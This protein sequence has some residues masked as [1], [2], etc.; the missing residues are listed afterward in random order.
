MEPTNTGRNA[1]DLALAVLKG[2]QSLIVLKAPISTAVPSDPWEESFSSKIRL[3]G[4]TKN[5]YVRLFDI[6]HQYLDASMSQDVEL[7]TIDSIPDDMGKEAVKTD[8]EDKMRTMFLEEEGVRTR[9]KIR[10]LQKYDT[11][12][13]RTV[14][15]LSCPRFNQEKLI[16]VFDG[17][18][19]HVPKIISKDFLNLQKKGRKLQSD[20]EID[21]KIE[22]VERILQGVP[23]SNL[24]PLH[25]SPSYKKYLKDRLFHNADGNDSMSSDS[26]LSSVPDEEACDLPFSM[27]SGE[28]LRAN[29]DDMELEN[30][31][32]SQIAKETA[33]GQEATSTLSLKYKQK[34]PDTSRFSQASTNATAELPRDS[35][36]ES[37][38]GQF[39]TSATTVDGSPAPVW[40]CPVFPW[41]DPDD[42]ANML[43]A[44]LRRL[45]NQSFTTDANK[46][47]TIYRKMMCLLV[48]AFRDCEEADCPVD[49]ALAQGFASIL[50]EERERMVWLPRPGGEDARRL[51]TATDIEDPNPLL[52]A[53]VRDGIW[54]RLVKHTTFR[55]LDLSEVLAKE[56]DIDVD[57]ATM[58][59]TLLHTT[60]FDYF[61]VVQAVR[62][63]GK[64]PLTCVLRELRMVKGHVLL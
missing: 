59:T 13:G 56:E 60:L 64:S 1:G 51:V 46:G 55:L 9:S 19:E 52:I 21:E 12:D 6:Q 61:D 3:K 34:P 26:S 50:T 17:D 38:E 31:Y 42:I 15:I 45:D 48:H 39:A 14:T 37:H 32:M 5:G 43:P 44:F 8:I 49:K 54:H 24:Q 16:V 35:G 4:C 10:Q 11:S 27:H 20:E 18:V 47:S 40:R 63:A 7:T 28:T 29:H 41:C 2:S 23:A 33:T 57:Q 30:L 58:L 36:Q 25:V 22:V 53:A 62:F